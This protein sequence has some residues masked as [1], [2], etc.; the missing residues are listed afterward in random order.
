MKC[1]VLA[2]MDKRIFA[3]VIDFILTL[4]VALGIFFALVLPLTL[5]ADE[6]NANQQKLNDIKI[7]SGL[8]TKVYSND[9]YAYELIIDVTTNKL[10]GINDPNAIP[11]FNVIELVDQKLSVIDSLA[12]F[13]LDPPTYNGAAIFNVHQITEAILKESIF[14]VG[15]EV[16]N[17]KDLSLNPSTNMYE[18]SLMDSSKQQTTIEYI[19]QLI[20]PDQ[21]EGTTS[22][23]EI[24]ITSQTYLDIENLNKNMMLFSILMIIPTLFG[25][26]LITY[27]IIPICSKNGE[28][29]GKYLLGLGVL[30]ADGYVLKKYYHIPRFLSLFVIEMAGG[31]LSF[32][33]LFLI[34]YIMFCFSKKRRSVHDFCA[35]SVVID[36]KEST[37]FVD[38]D[39]EYRYNYKTRID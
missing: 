30:T 22:V 3:A 7:A 12:R 39:Q 21:I 28:T 9:V 37:W 11:Y 4:G 10:N 6:Y 19:S 29:I 25:V 8:Y 1:I 16:S 34:S 14:K 31:I 35:N 2:K 20:K 27:F 23:S 26:S 13:Y 15:K 32:G 38:R 33:G 17:I 36:K 18:I 5:N 24:V